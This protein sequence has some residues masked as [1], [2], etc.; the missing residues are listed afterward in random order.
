MYHEHRRPGCRMEAIITSVRRPAVLTDQDPQHQEAKHHEHQEARLDVRSIMQPF[1][2]RSATL[3]HCQPLTYPG[4]SCVVPFGVVYYNPIRRKQVTTK[5]EL[6]RSLQ[7]CREYLGSDVRSCA[8]AFDML[9]FSLKGSLQIRRGATDG[10]LEA[11]F[12][13][14]ATSIQGRAP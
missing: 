7:V 8:E 5:K 12:A 6:H 10:A 4:D 14:S 11:P 9:R 13:R 1:E 2:F 3:V